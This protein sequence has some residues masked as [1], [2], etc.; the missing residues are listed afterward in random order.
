MKLSLNC[1]V[2]GTSDP[3]Y[4]W[5]WSVSNY[6]YLHFVI[7][8]KLNYSIF[9]RFKG[10]NQ[11]LTD[12]DDPHHIEVIANTLTVSRFYE[13]DAG[14]YTCQLLGSNNAIIDKKEFNVAC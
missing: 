1:N 10:A 8:F 11:I 5:K 9:F 13:A 6:N 14:S 7:I 2:E 4:T 12:S 3:K